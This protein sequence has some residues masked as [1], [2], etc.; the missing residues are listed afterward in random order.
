M[1]AKQ[2]SGGLGPL[3]RLG[4]IACTAI[5]ALVVNLLLSGV[6][7]P[8][9]PAG[10]A[11]EEGGRGGDVL[12]GRDDDNVNNP[13]IQPAGAVNQ[14]LDNADV[15][16]GDK[17]NDVLIGLLGNDVL[18]GGQGDDILVG[19]TEQ[20][21]RPNSDVMFGGQG[22]DIS[23]WAPGDGSDA[24]LGGPG[25]DAQLFGVIDRAN[26]V[27]T[28]TG[29]AP[30][31]PQGVPTANLTG[32]PGFCTLERVGDPA[33]GYEYLVRFFVRSTGALAVTVR[34]G[35][36]EQVFCTSQTGGAITFADLTQ[37]DPQFVEVTLEQVAALNPTVARI[38][39]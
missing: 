18:D 7:R 1:T 13:L 28:L 22:D 12:I 38:A 31:F 37:R 11:L 36:A 29:T 5:V 35:D 32:S 20:F 8:A 6:A 24:F 19:G 4:L 23:I 16:L 26:N 33:L 25:L 9:G 15:L 30:D 34:L 27:P 39:R 2:P 3:P 10:A 14:S 17:G 21:T